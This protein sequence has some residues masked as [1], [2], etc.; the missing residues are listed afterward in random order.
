M[1][2]KHIP[3]NPVS[4]M[5]WNL[6][7]GADFAPFFTATPKLIPHSV[8][9]VFR[10]FLATDFPLRAGT[11][12]RLIAS[13]KPDLIGLQ[14]ADRVQL[15]VPGL[16]VVTYD[17]VQLLLSELRKRGLHYAVAAKNKNVSIRLPTSHGDTVR[18]LDRD[19]ILIRK[20]SGLTVIR[21]QEANFKTNL[22]V[23]I[24]GRSFKIVRGWSS[25]DVL[26]HKRIFRMINTHLEPLSPS[27]QLAQ[28]N[29][30]LK[31]PANTNLP[32]IVLGD[33][34][35]NAGGKGAPTYNKFIHAGFK[36]VWKEAGKGSGFTCCQDADLLN[37]VSTLNS[38]IDFILFKNGWESVKAALS[39]N[40]Q[41]DRTP[42][43]LWPSD[44]A[45][46]SAALSF[47]RAIKS[48]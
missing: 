42:T 37:A 34:N 43:S 38:R 20:G 16:P 23:R 30:L 24:A 5:T 32:L 11:I 44:H 1:V 39:G 6:Y 17:F 48:V 14:E 13:K 33:F 8:T 27:V 47:A 45:A 46:V 18:L 29:E 21:R 36:D 41:S 9:E 35:S 10:Q 26:A 2:T 4:F 31:R 7:V 25:I 22:I 19:V 12:A 15:I 3:R 28:G 40:K